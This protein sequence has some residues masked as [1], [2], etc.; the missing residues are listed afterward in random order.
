MTVNEASPAARPSRFAEQN[1]DRLFA[2]AWAL[3][4][5]GTG[6]AV[7]MVVPVSATPRP[8]VGLWRLRMERQGMPHRMQLAILREIND[9]RSVGWPTMSVIFPRSDERDYVRA[10]DLLVSEGAV[11][12]PLTRLGV[13]VLAAAGR[14]TLTETGQQR[15]GGDEC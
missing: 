11:E 15:L 5:C 4:G 9:H 6:S 7:R 2:A 10:L 12:T 14:L 1:H 3:Q 13:R 8:C